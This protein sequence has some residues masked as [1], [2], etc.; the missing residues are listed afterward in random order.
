MSKVIPFPKKKKDKLTNETSWVVLY[1]T[2]YEY[3]AY[4]ICGLLKIYNIPHYLEC[5]KHIPHPVSSSQLGDYII[6]VSQDWIKT[7]K[8]IIKNA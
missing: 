2:P 1:K 4:L 6:W 8:A 7:A 5:L 3:E